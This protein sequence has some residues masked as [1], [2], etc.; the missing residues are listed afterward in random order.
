[1]DT[2]PIV[3]RLNVIADCVNALEQRQKLTYAEFVA[4]DATYRAV[5]RYFQI[6]IQAAIDIAGVL[7]ANLSVKVANGYA[8]VFRKLGEVGIVPPDFAERLAAMAGFRNVLV[9]MYLEVDPA[10]VYH[11]LQHDL[12]DLDEFVKHVARYVAGDATSGKR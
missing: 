12:S 2:T 9:H 1:M 7:L 6:A 11:A 5:E 3:A 10:K 4:D 8:D